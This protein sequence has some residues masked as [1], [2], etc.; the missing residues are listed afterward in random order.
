MSTDMEELKKRYKE[1]ETWEQY[2]KSLGGRT[3]IPGPPCYWK[4]PMMAEFYN[5]MK[6]G[7]GKRIFELSK[8]NK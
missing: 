2:Y 4:E 1:A 3:F 7:I 8:G 6:N 5:N